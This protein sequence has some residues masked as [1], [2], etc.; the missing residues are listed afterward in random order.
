MKYLM[1]ITTIKP[2]FV[3]YIPEDVADGVL[4][5]SIPYATAVHKCPCGCGEI[6]VTPIKP[7]DWF[8]TWNGETVT[9]KPS[10]G[11]FSLA[12][13]SH[14][15][16]IENKIIWARSD[17]GPYPRRAK[18]SSAKSLYDRLQEIR[19]HKTSTRK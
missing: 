8:L 11:N 14:Y 6:V 19:P 16:I 2:K 10:I 4:Y 9:L 18:K 1:K 12:C 13:Q 17:S 5:I 3:R 7:K 15:W